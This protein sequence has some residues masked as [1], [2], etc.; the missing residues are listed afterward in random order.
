MP[1]DDKSIKLSFWS[2]LVKILNY[3]VSI[4]QIRSS[5]TRFTSISQARSSL[6]PN[7]INLP[8]AR[9]SEAAR[10]DRLGCFSFVSIW[11]LDPSPYDSRRLSQRVINYATLLLY[12]RIWC[13]KR[14]QFRPD[15]TRCGF[16][17]AETLSLGRVGGG[18]SYCLGIKFRFLAINDGLGRVWAVEERCKVLY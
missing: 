16:W 1:P 6:Y 7:Q 13:T 11:T 18:G 8:I 9:Q 5:W 2:C 3:Q 10:C 12:L 15:W 14:L 4:S 17:R